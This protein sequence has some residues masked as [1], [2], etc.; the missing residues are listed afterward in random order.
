MCGNGE[1]AEFVSVY[2]QCVTQG[3]NIS[4]HMKKVQ[5][6]VSQWNEAWTA[7][8][9]ESE[10]IRGVCSSHS[11]QLA[12]WHLLERIWLVC[13]FMK[14]SP[15]LLEASP[16]LLFLQTGKKG[17]VSEALILPVTAAS[18]LSCKQSCWAAGFN[19]TQS[20]CN[21]TWP[22]HGRVA[23]WSFTAFTRLCNRESFLRVS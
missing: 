9:E 4:W 13:L 16:S 20:L 22:E 11:S 8:G 15:W 7:W 21:W 19:P 3:V 2:L 6:H 23:D 14:K 1:S 10:K 5:A 12:W 18:L 17:I